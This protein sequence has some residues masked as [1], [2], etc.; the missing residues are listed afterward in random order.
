[1]AVPAFRQCESHPGRPL[2]DH[3]SDV[4]D[5]LRVRAAVPVWLPLAG[6]FHDLGK[7]T[8]Y[9]QAYLQ[10]DDAP[11]ELKRHAEMGALWL[12]EFLCGHWLSAGNVSH[13]D[14]ALAFLFVRRHHGRLDD[15]LDSLTTDEAGI[16]RVR[17][18]LTAMDLP[19]IQDWLANELGLPIPVAAVEY[20]KFTELRVRSTLALKSVGT[21]ADAMTR[22][23]SSLRWFGLLIESDR[24]SAA[25]FAP[26]HFNAPP[27]LR[28]EHLDRFRA[29]GD[30]GVHAD[31]MVRRARE[32]VF[33]SALNSEDRD[34]A[35]SGR[36]WTLTVPTGSGK[37][38]AALGWA[39]KRRESRLAAGQE[40]CS[41]VYALPFTSIIDQNVAVIRR[42]LGETGGSENALA[43]H[44]HLAEAGEIAQSGE[45][46]LARSWV[47]GWRAD[48]VCTTFVQV[49]NALFHGTTA[50]ARRF[51][52]LAGSI[53]ILDEVQAFPAELWPVLRK[54]LYCL[55][56]H[57]GTDVLLVTA[58]QPA[59]FAEAETTEIGP[60]SFPEDVGRAFDRYDLV[61]ELSSPLKLDA[62]HARI[63]EEIE[64][65]HR[66]SCLVILNTVKEAL[67]LHAL[68][69][70]NGVFRGDALF[71]LST[72]LRPKDRARILREIQGCDKPHVLVST[73]VVEAGVDL[74]FDLVFRAL[75]PIDA[76]VQAAGRCNRHGIGNRGLVHVFDLEGNRGVLVYG[77]VHMGLAREIL[78]KFA[79]DG[80]QSLREPEL[81]ELVRRYFS[82]L[83]QRIGRGP[84]SKV[85]EA[86]R[87]LQFAALRGE[88]QDRESKEKRVQLIEDRFDRIA[89]FVETDESDVHVWSELCE[90]LGISD[91]LLRR[92][93]LRALR[94]EIAQRIVEVPRRYAAA[95]GGPEV[96]LVHIPRAQAADYYD[97]ATGWRRHE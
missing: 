78:S 97:P 75:A 70:S 47:E 22:F 55:S 13:V 4:A 23:Q 85:M 86:V 32:L 14:V 73:Q 8:A 96:H 51:S 27:Q 29:T 66:R 88:G 69:A 52:H 17:Q 44:H 56:K 59:L 64:G 57:F 20:K 67:D 34:A 95:G 43:I 26:G 54:A 58:T 41:I 63:A 53:L 65:K 87:M 9:F 35:S 94:S 37:T 89:H 40:N 15:L 77:A 50:D 60:R 82:E 18:Q 81:A 21:D 61:V 68:L 11:R 28:P 19:G 48:T 1:M 10:G 36:L 83:D 6:L 90:A 39:I 38:L 2:T 74:S 33:Q 3:L 76:L 92:Q 31:E 24:D 49:V 84:A 79:D 62:L 91:L 42:L 45:E 72:N 93:R 25:G 5:R 12:L 71:H 7:A 80:R 30:F 46:S 16:A